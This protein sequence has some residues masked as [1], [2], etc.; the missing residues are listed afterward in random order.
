M[1]LVVLALLLTACSSCSWLQSE[2]K[3]VA[4]DVVDCTTAQAKELGTQFGPVVDELLT[5]ATG[6]DG[7]VDWTRIRTATKSF[8]LDTGACVLASA[9]ARA[10]A[11]KTS[12]PNAP[13]AA[14]LEVDVVALRQGFEQLRNEAYGGKSFKTELGVL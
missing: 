1:R 10:L 4:G 8:A 14:G 7:S 11:P 12:D 9:V 6:N 2:S 13:Q 3:E 5:N